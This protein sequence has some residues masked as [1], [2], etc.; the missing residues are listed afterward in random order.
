MRTGD[1][2]ASARPR[3]G[4]RRTSYASRTE[5][6]SSTGMSFRTKRRGR[7]PKAEIRCSV[8]VSLSPREPNIFAQISL[9]VAR[10]C[11]SRRAACARRA[12]VAFALEKEVVRAAGVEPALCRQN[13]ILSPARL[14]VPP[15]PHQATSSSHSSRGATLLR[16]SI[17]PNLPNPERQVQR[18]ERWCGH[19]LFRREFHR[20]RSR[21]E[22]LQQPLLL[23]FGGLQLFCFHMAVAADFFRNRGKRDRYHM[24]VRR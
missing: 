17:A 13:W 8:T 2:R 3:I 14:P 7:G 12:S 21:A 18:T 4:L 9:A 23:G 24:I 6:S 16:L 15:R 1:S 5:F 10:Q 22:L 11:R 19:R 20:R